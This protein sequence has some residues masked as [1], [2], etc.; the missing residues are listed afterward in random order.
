MSKMSK[1]PIPKIIHLSYKS[2]EEILPEWKDVLSAWKK[3]N[4]TWEIKF[5]SDK[6]NEELVLSEFPWFYETYKKFK[7]NIQRADAVRCCYLF[8]YGGLYIDMDYL[9]INKIDKL[10]YN[11]INDNQIYITMNTSCLYF[12]NS[13]MASKSGCLF[14]IDYLKEIIKTKVKWYWTKS[15]EVFYTTGPFQLTKCIKKSTITFGFISPYLIHKCDICNLQ[16]D[17]KC[18][19]LY[20]KKIKGQSWNTIDIKLFNVL[21][22]NKYV[23]L[24]LFFIILY[25]IFYYSSKKYICK[26]SCT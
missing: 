24:I 15:L 4:P 3:T 5:W 6:D 9:P 11:N 1:F 21:F 19:S 25:L 23:S 8:K 14:W 16:N 26:Y 18:T 22:C 20:L 17:D 12:I 7:Y 10:F 2:K 13:F